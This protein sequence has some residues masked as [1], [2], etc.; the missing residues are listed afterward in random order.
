MTNTNEICRLEYFYGTLATAYKGIIPSLTAKDFCMIEE[1]GF[2]TLKGTILAMPEGDY[3]SSLMH[4][5]K[6]LSRSALR[7][8]SFAFKVDA[9]RIREAKNLQIDLVQNGRHVGTF[10]L[11]REKPDEFYT[12]AIEL[13]DDLRDL[14]PHKLVAPLRNKPGLLKRAEEIISIILSLKRDWRRLSEELNSFAKD[15]YWADRAAFR[16]WYRVLVQWSARV[17]DASLKESS[18]RAAANFLALAELPLDNSPEPEGSFEINIWLE[19]L[20]STGV[21]MASHLHQSVTILKRINERFPGAD[22]TPAAKELLQSLRD[23]VTN[24]PVISNAMMERLRSIL[25][26]EDLMAL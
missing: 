13:S 24:A 17:C 15:L 9:I 20:R 25:I 1:G 4:E 14:A 6:E 3:D 2:V 26:D 7:N 16:D 23:H 5:G 8:G 12:S 21:D 22:I 18:G 11:K 19:V 10:L